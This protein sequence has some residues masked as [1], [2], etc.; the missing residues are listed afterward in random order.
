MIQPLALS[1]APTPA[2]GLLPDF[3]RSIGD[4]QT[5]L[6]RIAKDPELIRQIE[7]AVHQMPTAHDLYLGD[8]RRMDV[9]PDSSVHLVLTSPPYWSLKKYRDTAGQIGAH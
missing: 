2:D 6:P 8:S 1:S 5:A 9:V 7:T 4:S 3:L